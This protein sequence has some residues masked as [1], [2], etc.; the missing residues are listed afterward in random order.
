MSGDA[1]EPET[2]Q[3]LLMAAAVSNSD[4]LI[5]MLLRK[6]GRVNGR[7]NQGW[8]PLHHCIASGSP[9]LYIA[10]Q[11]IGR[12][13]KTEMRDNTGVT[14]L[15]LA[16]EQGSADAICRL[17]EAGANIK[18]TD[19]EGRTV[20]HRCAAR[21]SVFLR[22]RSAFG[23]LLLLLFHRN[24]IFYLLSFLSFFFCVRSLCLFFS[25]SRRH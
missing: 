10:D 14:P 6:G 15:Q 19:N 23:S 5:R 4:I 13:A 7:C 20:L 3:S 12:G 17:I 2:G 21:E 8:T 11:L 9:Y 1:R 18:T 25:S 16:V 22:S 24:S